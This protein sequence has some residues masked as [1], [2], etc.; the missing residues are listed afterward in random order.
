[1]YKN[2][3]PVNNICSK[4]ELI[5]MG[6]KKERC[7]NC[8]YNGNCPRDVRKCEYLKKESIPEEE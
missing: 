8:F 1:M 6:R 3:Y 2:N 7:G 5:S 4:G